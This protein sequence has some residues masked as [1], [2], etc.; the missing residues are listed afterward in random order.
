VTTYT[1]PPY[2]VDEPDKSVGDLVG[3]LTEDFGSLVQSHVE[4]AKEEILTELKEAARGALLLGGS[5]VV[6]G[7]AI[8]IV[9]FAAAWGLA[10][11]VD[12][13]WLGF[14]LVGLLWAIV[15]GVLFMT[16]RRTIEDVQPPQKTI[17]ELEEDKRWLVEQ[18]S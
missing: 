14:L 6:G 8:L 5:A 10:E 18:T 3:E 11:I 1:Q 12:S 7:I 16:G 2:P 4:L 9:S 15:A 17:E 13:V